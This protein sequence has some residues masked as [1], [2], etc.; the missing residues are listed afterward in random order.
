MPT[1]EEHTANMTIG[2]FKAS[3]MSTINKLYETIDFVKNG[4]EEKNLLV[5]ALLFEKRT[6]TRSLIASC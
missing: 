1:V 2:V 4:I 6:M 5:K 3:L